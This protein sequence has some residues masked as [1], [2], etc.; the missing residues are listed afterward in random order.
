VLREAERLAKAGVKELL[1]ISQDTSAYGVDLKYAAGAG[2]A[3][4]RKTRFEDLARGARRARRLGP[5]CT[6]S[7]RIRTSIA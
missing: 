5:H 2:T 7:I 3:R 4:S 1:V 6:T